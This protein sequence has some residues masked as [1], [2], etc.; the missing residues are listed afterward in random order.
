MTGHR[1][2]LEESWAPA[3]RGA[4]LARRGGDDA[5]KP[6]QELGRFDI[7]RGVVVC[8]VSVD[9]RVRGLRA[10][11]GRNRLCRAGLAHLALPWVW[12]VQGRIAARRCVSKLEFPTQRE[13]FPTSRPAYR[14]KRYSRRLYARGDA[15]RRPV[16]RARRR[17]GG[18]NRIRWAPRAPPSASALVIYPGK[19]LTNHSPAQARIDLLRRA[20]KA[21]IFFSIQ[22]PRHTPDAQRSGETQHARV[23]FEHTRRAQRRK[24]DSTF[25]EP[26]EVAR[27]ARLPELEGEESGHQATSGVSK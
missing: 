13:C 5:P 19:Q 1:V 4:V 23:G 7:T 24:V 3:E 27:E 2:G 10:G 6:L 9:R 16:S 21:T 11:A 14:A 20:A 22:P 25:H 8:G 26:R 18:E 12:T 15:A 17:H